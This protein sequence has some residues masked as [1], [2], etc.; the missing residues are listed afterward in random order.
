MAKRLPIVEH[1]KKTMQA[2]KTYTD[3]LVLNL[4]QNVIESL[5]KL[6][7]SLLPPDG[8][9]GQVLTKASED[10]EQKT[11]WGGYLCNK[12]L[13]RNWY[14]PNPINQNRKT[15]YATA[16][17]TIDGW[18]IKNNTTLKLV[19]KGLDGRA[20]I[21]S[22]AEG[23]NVV[24]LPFDNPAS[25]SGK[26]LT[27]SVLFD[28]DANTNN[29]IRACGILQYSVS[30]S[31]DVTTV[32]TPYLAKNTSEARG[33]KIDLLSG[34]TTLPD[35]ISTLEFGI[36]FSDPSYETTKSGAV[37][38]A[39]KVEIGD[40]QTLGH[41]EGDVWILNEIPNYEEQ[42]TI[43]DQ[44]S[45]ISNE[46]KAP[47]TYPCNE[48][49]FRNWYFENPVNRQGKT[50]Y[51]ETGRTIDGWKLTAAMSGSKSLSSLIVDEN[52]IQLIYKGTS[53]STSLNYVF[54]NI[55]LAPST[56]LT[57]SILSD[58][59]LYFGTFSYQY[60]GSAVKLIPD[61]LDF[62]S[63]A[64]GINFRTSSSVS[65]QAVK[66]E[67]GT[68]QT[69][70]HKEG[71]KWVL[72]EIPD[73][74]EQYA[75]CEKYD[76]IDGLFIGDLYHTYIGAV[77]YGKELT[78]S[79][80][81]LSAR[82]KAGNMVGIRIGDY[83][84][85]TLDGGEQVVME[86]AGI[87]QYYRCGDQEI[88][89]H[90]DFISRDCLSGTKVFN[91]TATNNG[92]AA[93]PNPW[94]ASKLFKTLNEEVWAKIPTDLKSYII[95]KRALLES[96]YSA[97]GTVDS[98]TG[99]AWNNAGK[100]WLPKEIEVFGNIFWSDFSWTGGG[101]CN[102]QYPIFY[103]GTKHIIKGAGNGGGRCY[104]WEASARYQSFANICFVAGN[105]E[106]GNYTATYN[107]IYVPLCFRI[108]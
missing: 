105:G 97:T 107:S 93:E 81:S 7:N 96:R 53:T 70:A 30:G 87:D 80:A 64:S 11:E 68:N 10:S 29:A 25:F 44:Y 49:L 56:K 22:P 92:T 77:P 91:D 59:E 2:G 82:I 85:I 19:K 103:G 33:A 65:L 67:V 90:V 26:T 63:T 66:L 27:F 40:I 69:L 99:W 52:G 8:N 54:D 45:L 5:T 84:T 31:D 74:A 101:G 83:K 98:D 57:I 50:E 21:A 16:G 41:L 95:E 3:S 23:A 60:A 48:N 38:V 17:F 72:N 18:Y 47:L 4:T 42:R 35:D 94:R 13:L 78:E 51:T 76:P 71:D 43:C 62:Y 34:T 39:A 14:F 12:N 61:K 106:S 36:Q 108:G 32:M 86:V 24:M 58:D 46:R 1:L 6:E 79:W 15:S 28:N 89:H 9:P 73:Y 100:L 88:G 20:R 55:H 102:L 37:A 104:W 75:I